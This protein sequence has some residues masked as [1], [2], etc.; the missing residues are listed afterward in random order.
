MQLNII[1]VIDRFESKYAILESQDKTP[2]IFNSP[3][4]LFSPDAK[5]GSVLTFNIEVDNKKTTRRRNKIIE[6]LNK[7]KKKDFKDMPFKARLFNTQG[8]RDFWMPYQISRSDLLFDNVFPTIWYKIY[9]KRLKQHVVIRPSTRCYMVGNFD[10]RKKFYT[11]DKKGKGKWATNCSQNDIWGLEDLP[12]KGKTLT[13]TKS[14][15]DYRVVKNQGVTTI[16]FQNE[17]MLP[18]DEI[19][20]PLLERFEEVIILFD[21]D[22]AGIEAAEKVVDYINAKY[23]RKARYIHIKTS[24][25][26]NLISDPADFIAKKGKKPLT[27][28]LIDNKLIKI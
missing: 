6:K 4:H 7:L 2:L 24:L 10:V 26:K 5:E 15:K 22:R 1:L 14:Y 8:D 17:G 13:I 3:R 11:P 27:E 23:P 9:S 25:N 12:L 21:N 18:D 20:F 28:F 19:L 16:A